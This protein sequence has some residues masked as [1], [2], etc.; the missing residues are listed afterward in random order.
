MVKMKTVEGY[1]SRAIANRFV[2][3]ARG[4]RKPLDIMSLLKF[5]YI[6]HGW[7]LAYADRALICH[8]VEAWKRGPVIPKVY[9]AFRQQGVYINEQ[10]LSADGAP[11]WIDLSNDRKAVKII[12]FVYDNYS[13][14]GPF[15]LSDVTHREGTPWETVLYKL[16]K[17]PYAQI[18]NNIIKRYYK[19]YL[20]E[21]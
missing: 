8:S 2:V 5:V 7:Y 1:D 16:Y 11:Y 9:F 12:D 6:A 14:L 3:K 21:R 17:G 4:T 19:N 20:N 10:A 18:S 13:H 15:Q